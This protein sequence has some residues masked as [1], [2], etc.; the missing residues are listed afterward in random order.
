MELTHLGT[1]FSVTMKQ[2]QPY[3][4]EC[5]GESALGW[6]WR[7]VLGIKDKEFTVGRA[8]QPAGH[9]CAKGSVPGWG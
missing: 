4:V 1:V 8:D 3:T 9:L 2:V 6:A 7:S 5:V